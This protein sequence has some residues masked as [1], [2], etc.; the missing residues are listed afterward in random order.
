MK[1]KAFPLPSRSANNH[2][3]EHI[4]SITADEPWT[5]DQQGDTGNF[6]KDVSRGTGQRTR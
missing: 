2:A 6:M 4:S 1:R 5:G 3:A